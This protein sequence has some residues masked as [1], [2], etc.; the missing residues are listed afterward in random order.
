MF[1]VQL[2]HKCIYNTCIYRLHHS[3]QADTANNKFCHLPGIWPSL[4]S[5]METESG[6]STTARILPHHFKYLSFTPVATVRLICAV[7]AHD[8]TWCYNT[9]IYS[10]TSKDCRTTRQ[11]FGNF[12]EAQSNTIGRP[13]WMQVRH[14]FRQPHLTLQRFAEKA[15]YAICRIFTPCLS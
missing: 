3:K 14:L 8:E 1:R 2:L 13:T 7:A 10:P 6:G 5:V 12:D 15:Q 4:K 9:I 11:F